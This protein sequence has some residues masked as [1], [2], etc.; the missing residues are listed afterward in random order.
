MSDV[1]RLA[2]P[3]QADTPLREKVLRRLRNRPTTRGAAILL[4]IANHAIDVPMHI[5]DIQ[6]GTI[7]DDITLYFAPFRMSSLMLLSG[8]LL[9][10]LALAKPTGRY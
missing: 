5:A 4:V 3:M 2:G 8:L 6:P 10:L 9:L 1:S 7:V